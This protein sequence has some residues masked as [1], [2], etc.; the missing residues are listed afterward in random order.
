[1]PEALEEAFAAN[2]TLALFRAEQALLAQQDKLAQYPQVNLSAEPGRIKEGVFLGPVARLNLAL[3]LKEGLTLEGALSGALTEEGVDVQPVGTLTLKYDFLAPPKIT[4]HS[5]EPDD[6]LRAEQNDLVLQIFELFVSLRAKLEEELLSQER[7]ALF[8]L[9]LEAAKLIADYDEKDL[10][11]AYVKE[12]ESL[13]IL[14][15][16]ISQLQMDLTDL[17]GST[18]SIY[19]QF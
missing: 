11:K 5:L 7:L 1:M 9:Q 15:A 3:P 13:R 18:N 14:T 19:A 8:E 4:S 10:T 6:K 16:E 2:E 17:L 12:K